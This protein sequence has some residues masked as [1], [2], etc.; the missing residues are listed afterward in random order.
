MA[1]A[2]WLLFSAEYGNIRGVCEFE[3]FPDLFRRDALLVAEF[4]AVRSLSRRGA[5]RPQPAGQLGVAMGAFRCIWVVDRAARRGRRTRW[6]HSVLSG[7]V[8]GGGTKTPKAGH[9]GID[10]SSPYVCMVHGAAAPFP[11]PLKCYVVC[12]SYRGAQVLPANH[13][14]ALLLPTRV[15]LPQPETLF[16]ARGVP[17]YLQSA[18][19]VLFFRI[20]SPAGVHGSPPTPTI[21]GPQSFLPK[22]ITYLLGP[23]GWSATWRNRL[24]EFAEPARTPS[25]YA[26]L[27]PPYRP[28]GLLCNQNNNNCSDRLLINPGDSRPGPSI[29]LLRSQ[30][31]TWQAQ[32]SPNL[33]TPSTARIAFRDAFRCIF[34]FFFFIPKNSLSFATIS[35]CHLAPAG[36]EPCVGSCHIFLTTIA[37]RFTFFLVLLSY[38][39]FIFTDR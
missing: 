28:S 23:Y 39:F 4:L 2:L 13:R 29:A 12:L 24:H 35:D 33:C 8:Y 9:F 27:R 37:D 21:L 25:N 22:C 7:H 32:P 14:T 15:S 36:L 5:T 31:G 6:L 16:R 17:T 3:I 18:F 30:P 20:A 26:P 1:R 38:I 34:Y 19:T 10:P 11:T